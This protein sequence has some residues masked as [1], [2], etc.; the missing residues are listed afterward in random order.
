[1][2]QVKD[3]NSESGDTFTLSNYGEEVVEFRSLS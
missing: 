3:G 1:M 2:F